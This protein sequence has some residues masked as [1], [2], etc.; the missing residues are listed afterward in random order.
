MARVVLE[1]SGDRREVAFADSLTVGRVRKPG[2]LFLEDTKLSREHARISFD[3][4]RWIVEDLDSRNGTLLN[5]QALRGPR[6]LAIGDEIRLGGAV[7]R[8]VGDERPASFQARDRG[9]GPAARLFMNVLLLAA[10]G[11]GV[12]GFRLLF[13]NVLAGSPKP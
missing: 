5:G 8:F 6:A 4:S 13:L 9:F 3:G 7:L 10:F 2:H 12:Y 11:A 1:F